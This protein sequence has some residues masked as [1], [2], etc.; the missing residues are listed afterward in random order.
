[1]NSYD[2]ILNF[3]K[4][5]QGLKLKS[6]RSQFDGRRKIPFQIIDYDSEKLKI[7]FESGTLLPLHSWRFETAMKNLN[8]ET[9]IPIGARISEDYESLSLEGFLIE[10][11]RKQTGNLTHTK[12]APHI[13]D[14]LVLAGI[15]EL[16]W[17]KSEMG[18]KV[19]GIRL[20]PEER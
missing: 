1:M 17:A 12:T 4:I 5:S 18:R 2:K 13:A 10:E 14:I 20:K 19:Q 8:K 16:G 9:F 15:A 7:K 11:Y 6:P 3:A